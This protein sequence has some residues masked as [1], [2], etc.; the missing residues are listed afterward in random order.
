MQTANEIRG[1]NPAHFI[2]RFIHIAMLV[3]PIGYYYFL[4]PHVPEKI[5]HVGILVFIFLVFLFEKLRIRV[6][7]VLFA[8]RLHEASHLSAFAWTMLAI[9]IILFSLPVHF[10]IPIIATCAFVDPLMGELRLHHVNKKSVIAFGIFLALL[11]WFIC[12][13]IY[14]FSFWYGILPAIIAVIIEQP[15][16][17]WIDDNALMLLVP[18]LVILI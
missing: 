11:I 17:K 18:M 6:R 14:H 15:N 5:L 1:G 3:I 13:V 12:A 4:V 9:G 16:L 2:R 10:A 7:L 8:Q